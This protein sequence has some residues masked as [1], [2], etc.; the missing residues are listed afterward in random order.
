M[1]GQGGS[2]IGIY[3]SHQKEE[4]DRLVWYA[5]F[6]LKTEILRERDQEVAALE[7]RLPTKMNE[8]C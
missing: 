5:V 3:L 1:D 8:A 6:G 2:T 4:V 7:T